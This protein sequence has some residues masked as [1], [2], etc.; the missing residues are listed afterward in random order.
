MALTPLAGQGWG[1]FV[2][3]KGESP[4]LPLVPQLWLEL[5]QAPVLLHSVSSPVDAP[6]TLGQTGRAS[7][8][9]QNLMRATANW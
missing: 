8:V 6:S 4:L 2:S 1:S 7:P 3:F 5:A 9:S